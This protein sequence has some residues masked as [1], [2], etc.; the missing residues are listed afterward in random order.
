MILNTKYCATR[1]RNYAHKKNNKKPQQPQGFKQRR[2]NKKTPVQGSFLA[3]AKLNGLTVCPCTCQ[4]MGCRRPSVTY[5]LSAVG[6][7]Q[8]HMPKNNRTFGCSLGE[9]NRQHPMLPVL[10]ILTHVLGLPFQ[11]VQHHNRVGTKCYPI[12]GYTTIRQSVSTN[13]S[14]FF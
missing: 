2:D 1:K 6:V 8:S 12:T 14:H 11:R 4:S 13:F 9:R 5:H 10:A 7:N 3:F